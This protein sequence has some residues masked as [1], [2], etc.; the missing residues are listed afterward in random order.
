MTHPRAGRHGS[1]IAAREL[2]HHD[3]VFESSISRRRTSARRLRLAGGRNRF[4]EPNY[5]AVWG[6]SRLELDGREVGR[7]RRG[8]RLCC[9]NSWSLRRVPKYTPH[10]R[11]H[12]ER[13]LPPEAYGSP[14]DWYA[15]TVE[16]ENGGV[17][18]RCRRWGRIPRKRR[19]RALLHAGQG[20]T[21]SS[22]S[23]RQPWPNMSRGRSK[24][25]RASAGTGAQRSSDARNNRNASTTAGPGT[26]SDS[27]VRRFTGRHS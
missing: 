22:C 4:G 27:G 10:D 6:W 8:R 25:A 12:I 13:W 9:A 17:A 3:P 26:C 7:P 23:S 19:I 15:Q 14:Q 1:Y 5:R 21:A 2:T 18:Q 11:W 24:R 20:R 16:R